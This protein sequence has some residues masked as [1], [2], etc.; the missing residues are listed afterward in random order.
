MS[1]ELRWQKQN[2]YPYRHTGKD[3]D[4]TIY[5]PRGDWGWETEEEWE[6]GEDDQYGQKHKAAKVTQDM[7]ENRPLK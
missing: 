1:S 2:Q 4:K 5:T 3:A 6:T 7:K